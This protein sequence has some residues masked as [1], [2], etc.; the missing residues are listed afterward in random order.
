MKYVIIFLAVILLLS[1]CQ[2]KEAERELRIE[3][4]ETLDYVAVGK[5]FPTIQAPYIIDVKNNNK[6]IVF[7]GCEHIR[8]TTHQQFATIEKYFNEL[9]PQIAFNEG[10]QVHD[11][12]SS[13]N[14]AVSKRGETGCL[15]YLCDKAGIK[16]M[17]GDTED[18]V[19]FA[20]TLKKHPKDK[21]FLYYIMERVVIPYLY[22]A[23]GDGPFEETYERSVKNWFVTNGYPLSAD[24]QDVS[25][26]KELYLK[27]VGK[28]FKAELNE[29]IE[30]F[31]Y[32]N[33]GDCE[34]CEIGRTSKMVRDS[35][36]LSK[37]DRALDEYD[38]VM[39]TFGHGHALAVE[40]ALKQI[41]NK[42]RKDKELH[43]T[44]STPADAEIT[45][46]M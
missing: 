41:I 5:V 22:G 1:S 28:P 46:P 30:K 36:L 16:M 26:F 37:I 24:E 7:V 4:Y 14:E 12:F 38:R 18:S 20:I 8:D 11:S 39:V 9:K 17:N 44:S 15:K 45:R 19:E 34:F 10:G 6:R 31:D 35:V 25:Y 43:T 29:D 2:T 3:K 32:I 13:F 42:I 23:Y 33:G 40:P 27:Y 21:L